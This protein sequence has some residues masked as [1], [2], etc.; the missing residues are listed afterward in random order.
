MTAAGGLVGVV[1]KTR[2]PGA[3][4]FT[5]GRFKAAHILIAGTGSQVVILVVDRMIIGGVLLVRDIA[6]KSRELH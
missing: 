1:E 2:E 6:V 3:G 5:Q 4:G